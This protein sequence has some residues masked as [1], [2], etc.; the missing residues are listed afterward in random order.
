MILY[1][2][3]RHSRYNKS[4]TKTFQFKFQTIKR[5]L[6]KTEIVAWISAGPSSRILPKGR[7]NTQ[8]AKSRP[9][10]RLLYY[11]C[12]TTVEGTAEIQNT[13]SVTCKQYKLQI[14]IVQ[15]FLIVK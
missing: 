10:V 7:L 12:T 4:L 2:Q 8:A 3:M 13:E 11:Y 9:V 14:W 15:L 1:K 6:S 5:V